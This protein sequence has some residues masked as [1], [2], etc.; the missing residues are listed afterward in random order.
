MNATLSI[1]QKVGDF[2]VEEFVKTSSDN[3]GESYFVSDKDGRKA[4]MKLYAA[5]AESHTLECEVNTVLSIN[6]AF[7]PM[8]A[9]GDIEHNGVAF[10]Y[11][12][13]EYVEGERLSE[14]V[15]AGR[16]YSWEEA[17]PII[18]QV[19]NALKHL[20]SLDK[21]IIHN[22]ITARNILIN[23]ERKQ[24]YIIGMGHMSHQC[25][26]RATFCTKDLN[27]WYRAPETF[28][29]IYGVKSDIFSVGALL[30]TMLVGFEP[31]GVIADVYGPDVDKSMLKRLRSIGDEIIDDIQITD[32]QKVILGKM[33]A[34]DYDKRYSCVDD[35]VKGIIHGV[36]KKD[37][38]E[39][40]WYR[41]VNEEADEEADVE[42]D[43]EEDVD[44]DATTNGVN[45][46]FADVAGM[47]DVKSMLYKEVMF[48][49]QNKEKARKYRLKAPNGVLF[50]GPP[51]CGKTF[52]AEKFAEES[53]L[54]FMMVKASD[55]GSIYIHGSQ[56]KIAELFDEATKKAPT[57]ICFDELD[58]MVPDRTSIQ[59]EGLSGEVNEFL[60]QLNNC[61]DRGIFVIGTSNR[62]EKIDPAILRTGRMDKMVYIPMPDAEAR[63]ELFKIYLDDRYCDESIDLD[64]LAQ[65]SEGYVAS[66]ISFMANESALEAA[67]ADVPITQDLV[68]GV[69]RKARRSVTQNDAADYERM[70]KKFEQQ[71]Y[72]HERHRI[73]Y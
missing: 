35:V 72:S 19:L 73:G 39:S 56:G 22:D 26:G 30:Y 57:V 36:S 17:M 63:K 48:V 59:N 12:V 60:S 11:I 61:S 32:E 2:C 21:A 28:K 46:G 31:W 37:L 40:P 69:M 45:G 1:G 70:R 23:E 20:H 50:Y 43:I 13:R 55:L 38:Q 71:S 3:R 62:P 67:M 68:L 18:L 52:I 58:G 15:K 16:L 33:I 8:V 25:N 53:H 66:D 4:L 65:K 42:L 24:V 49:M 5:D 64:E 41:V 6:S 34:L 27:N 10:R 47:A 44:T 9:V 54:N 29:G 51:G 14:I 7:V